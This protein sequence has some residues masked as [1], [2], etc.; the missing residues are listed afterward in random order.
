MDDQSI[1][2]ARL[3]EEM[4]A[5]PQAF[6]RAYYTAKYKGSVAEAFADRDFDKFAAPGAPHIDPNL[7]A[8]DLARLWAASKRCEDF[9]DKRV[10]HRD[11]REPKQLPTFNEVD[12]C[13]DLLDELCVKYLRLFHGKAP[14]TLLPT[15]QYDWKYVFRVPWLPSSEEEI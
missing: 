7:V 3:F 13:I 6:P 4:I 11:E 14:H 12:S 10:A 9:A 1:S 5:A 8:A 2:M 15:W